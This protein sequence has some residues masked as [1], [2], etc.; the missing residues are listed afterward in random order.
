MTPAA[1][2]PAS[3]ALLAGP[4]PSLLHAAHRLLA[5][6]AARPPP[7]RAYPPPTP[8]GEAEPLRLARKQ[9]LASAFLNIDCGK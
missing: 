9:A 7:G 5:A 3:S 8:L 6:P 1:P 4:S 2:V